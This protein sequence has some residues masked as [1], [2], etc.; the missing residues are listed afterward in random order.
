[1][2]SNPVGVVVW[3]VD[4]TLIPADLRWLR[5]AIARTYSLQEDSVVFPTKRV[6]GYTDESIVVDTAI[7]S[8]V[9]AAVAEAGIQRFHDKMAQVMTEGRDELARDQ[10]A[11]PGAAE[12]IVALHDFGFIQ[13]VLTGNIRVAAEIKLSV[14]GLDGHLDLGIG[15][16]GSDA[17]DRFLLPAVI[18]D[19]FAARYGVSLEPTRTVVIGDAPNDIACARHA[20]FHVI[21]VAH[22]IDRDELAQHQ[23][24]AVLDRLEPAVVVAT[25]RSL[26]QPSG[27]QTVTRDRG[28]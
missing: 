3:D 17:R 6:H 22:R 15:G 19:R 4:G 25:V 26:I 5:R 9:Q 11:Y 23:P 28:S 14:A 27:S 7:G 20:G 18:A 8:G 24:D 13:T 16:Y 12:T 10:P 2:S 21:A 1:M